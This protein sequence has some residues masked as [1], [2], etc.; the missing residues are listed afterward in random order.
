MADSTGGMQRCYKIFQIPLMLLQE[1]HT[2][3]GKRSDSG[4]RVENVTE[5]ASRATDLRQQDA[6]LGT[7]I[8]NRILTAS[9][10]PEKRHIGT[11]IH[12]LSM[13]EI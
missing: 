4:L 1:Y 6:A 13:V 12:F 5:G 10:V 9:G 8:E 11:V 7:V 3:V 2:A